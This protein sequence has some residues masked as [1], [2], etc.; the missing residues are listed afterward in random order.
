VTLKI[1]KMILKIMKISVEA[2]TNGNIGL[3]AA[4]TTSSF[5][6]RYPKRNVDGNSYFKLLPKG[7]TV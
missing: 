6:K 2:I 1:L 7:L 3:N 5:S 4:L